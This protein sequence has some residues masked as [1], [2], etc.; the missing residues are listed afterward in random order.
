MLAQAKPTLKRESLQFVSHAK[1]A[2]PGKTSHLSM[3]ADSFIENA[4]TAILQ[5]AYA[6]RHDYKNFCSY[7]CNRTCECLRRASSVADS[8]RITC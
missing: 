8:G 7:F 3:Q 2:I 6:G 5:V 1:A 4:L